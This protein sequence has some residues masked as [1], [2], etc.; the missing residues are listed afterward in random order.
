MSISM[1]KYTE[2]IFQRFVPASH[3]IRSLPVKNKEA[4]NNLGIAA[5]TVERDAMRDKPYLAA[6]A[7]LLWLHSTLRADISVHVATLCQYMHDP[8]PAAWAA[9]IDLIAYTHYSKAASITYSSDSAAWMCPEEYDGDRLSFNASC[10]L[11]GFCDSS[12]KLRSLSGHVIFIA[13]GPIDWAT[14]LIRT[15]CHSSAEAEVAAGCNLA[16]SLVYVRQ[17]VSSLGV[18]LRSPTP[19]FIDSQAAILIASNLGV[20][21]RTLHFERWQHYLRLCVARKVLFLIHVVTQRQRADGLTKIVDATAQRWLF[22]TL[23]AR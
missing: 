19:V 6:C 21:K 20:T 22:K 9:V 1:Q 15:V 7:S 4:F 5:S 17:L 18:E 11:H 13:G 14:K 16:K 3:P 12:W 2:G 10:G 23:F 8:S